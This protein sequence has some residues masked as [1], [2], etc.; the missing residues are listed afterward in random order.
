M[1]A[2]LRLTWRDALLSMLCIITGS[3]FIRC[4]VT[5]PPN[6]SGTATETTN[7]IVVSAGG[8]PQP[9]AVV[10]RIFSNAWFDNISADFPVF[11]DSAITNWQGRFYLVSVRKPFLLSFRLKGEIC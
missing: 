2:R 5:P 11:Y 3:L 4:S 9:D 8:Q 7:G 6:I 1:I 10:R